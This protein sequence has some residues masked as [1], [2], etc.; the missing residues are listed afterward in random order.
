MNECTPLI[1]GSLYVSEI[2]RM[3]LPEFV[4]PGR[5]YVFSFAQIP[6][7]L[8]TSAYYAES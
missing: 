2:A 8:P 4:G 5:I 7:A 6:Y 3:W 1:V